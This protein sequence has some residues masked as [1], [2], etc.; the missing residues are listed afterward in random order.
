MNREELREGLQ[1]IL[2]EKLELPDTA[3]REILEDSLRLNADLYVDSVRLL[4]LIVYIEED[5]K[6]A[7]PEEELD[8][9]GLDT[10]G[11]LLDFMEDLQPLNAAGQGV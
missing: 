3:K 1:R 5:L 2:T 8:F 6:L 9:Q 11:A 7:V 10:V 4:Q